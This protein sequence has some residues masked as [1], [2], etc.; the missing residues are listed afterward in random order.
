MEREEYPVSKGKLIELLELIEKQSRDCIN[1]FTTG[2]A[3]KEAK[4]AFVEGKLEVIK[5]V[6]GWL[7]E[8]LGENV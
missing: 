5:E 3:S 1:E 7:A 8:A 2:T 4:A 6:A